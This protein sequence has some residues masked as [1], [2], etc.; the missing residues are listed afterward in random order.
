MQNLI[1]ISGVE[2]VEIEKTM[3]SLELVELINKV[4]KQEFD[5]G[6]RKKFIK[7]QHKH[8]LNKVPLVIGESTSRKFGS[9]YKDAKGEMRPSYKLPERESW[10]M[11]MS[12][13]YTLQ[14]LIYDTLQEVFKQN[15]QLQ[16]MANNINKLA[17]RV[18][19]NGSTWGKMGNQQK[20]NKRLIDRIAD[21][22]CDVAQLQL[23]YEKLDCH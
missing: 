13:S 8:F 3:T 7:L 17:K 5:A 23:F 2:T 21:T 15:H 19:L 1:L 11:A 22:L 12:Y 4:R 6:K 16:D 14:A 9:S 10:L 18:E 20:K